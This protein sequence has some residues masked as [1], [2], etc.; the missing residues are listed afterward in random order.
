MVRQGELSQGLNVPLRR[1]IAQLME[2]LPDIEIYSDDW[3]LG[4]DVNIAIGAYMYTILTSDF[5]W[6]KQTEPADS[7]SPE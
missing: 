7:T 4:E 2:N 3:H 6:A 5:A 1:L